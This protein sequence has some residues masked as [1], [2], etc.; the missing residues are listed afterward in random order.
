MGDWLAGT[1]ADPDKEGRVH[2]DSGRIVIRG[3][4]KSFGPV[5]AVRDLD[6]VVQP[7]AVT[8]FFGPNGSGKTTT[9]RMLLGLV[10]PTAG[11]STINGV[12]FHQL[13]HPAS[14]VGAV[15]DTQSF[16]PARTAINHLRCYAAA[17]DVPDAQAA[18]AIELVGLHSAAHRKVGTFSLGMRQRL[19]LATALLGDPRILVLDEPA[20]G[21]DPEG[22]AWLR[23]FL[24]TFAASGRT[25]LAS[26]HLL[27]EMEHAVDNVVI[28]SRGH[29]V[30]HGH[31]DQL[32]AAQPS[33]VLV[34]PSDPPALAHALQQQGHDV[35]QFADGRLAVPGT[36]TRTVAELALRCGIA[37]HEMRDERADL[38]H[39]FFQL[40]SGQFAG[41][42]YTSNQPEDPVTSEAAPADPEDQETPGT[43][44]TGQ[45]PHGPGFGGNS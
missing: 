19:A 14:V 26:S 24:R 23:N 2:D 12:P 13:P 5:H 25:V 31:V 40:T 11:T 18:R 38:E 28:I 33:R 44:S 4:S 15:L 39:L 17:M 45:P 32:R 29:C 7:G 35:E 37:V 1:R 10:N 43:P 27:R 8:G 6:F 30:Y 21:L 34:S 20:N 42:Q 36:D 22:I 16:H 9:L 41:D 3:L